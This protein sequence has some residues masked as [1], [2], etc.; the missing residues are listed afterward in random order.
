MKLSC[1]RYM[2][3]LV[4]RSIMCPLCEGPCSFLQ[5]QHLAVCSMGSRVPVQSVRV[6]LQPFF[7]RDVSSLA[8]VDHH[9]QVHFFWSVAG[10]NARVGSS[11]SFLCDVIVCVH[12]IISMR[13][14]WC[15]HH[16]G[17]V[18]DILSFFV[19]CA[20]PQP[21]TSKKWPCP[22]GCWLHAW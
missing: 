22:N 16:V 3:L 18:S 17:I 9:R 21:P 5:W 6:P 10:T 14:A 20:M 8:S 2:L 4:P 15:M 1:V 13:D 11:G 19:I 7:S 12:Y